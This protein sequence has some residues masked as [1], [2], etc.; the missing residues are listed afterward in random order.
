MFL[1]DAHQD[2]A[3][4][5]LTFGRDYTLSAAEI[6]SIEIDSKAPTVNGDTLLGW[7]EYQEGRV[8]VIIASLFAAPFR[9]KQGE[10]DTL[11]YA[12]D[13][14]AFTLYSQQLDIYHR[15]TEEHHDKF[16]LVQTQDDLKFVL[17]HWERGDDLSHPV[18]LV[19]LME[20]AEAIN[21]I[22]ELEDWWNRGVR[23][24]GPA[25][26]GT[27]FCGGTREPGPLTKEGYALLEGMSSWGYVLDISH[28]DERAALQTLDMYNHKIIASHAN[29]AALL[30]GVDSNRFLSNRL[31]QGLI[32]REGIVGIIPY[33]RF[34][35]WRW[36][37]SDG[38]EAVSLSDVVAQIDYI[39]QIA[40][41]ACHVGIGS[42]FDGGFGLQAVPSELDTIVDLHK[43]TP[44][45]GERGY[46][47]D[48]IAAIM[49]ENWLS[50]LKQTLPE[51]L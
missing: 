30:P 22:S 5:I 8:A 33:N 47:E 43:I 29:A 38:R 28:M 40:G 9:R 20:G 46:T 4:N 41:D 11:C 26:A 23:L 35:K 42:D 21:K 34:L 12:N 39:C 3:W 18:G 19:I 49:G 10:W 13:T 25:W 31:I 6:R 2:L 1:I 7:P 17:D 27:R 32:E 16:K 14:Q 45:L 44:L 37:P 51:S 24:I 36:T 15:L 50:L 48:D